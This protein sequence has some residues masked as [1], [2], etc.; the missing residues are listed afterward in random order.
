MEP[1][2]QEHIKELIENID[3]IEDK[4]KAEAEYQEFLR[5]CGNGVNT[6][7]ADTI[8]DIMEGKR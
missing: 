4:A 5:T 8:K 1:T 2:P 3:N 7:I 6:A